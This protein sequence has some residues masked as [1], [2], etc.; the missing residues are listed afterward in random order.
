MLP[1]ALLRISSQWILRALDIGRNSSRSVLD[2]LRM[3]L[4][5]YLL[6]DSQAGIDASIQVTFR[7]TIGAVS[8]CAVWPKMPWSV[9][10]RVV[11][12]LNQFI[13]SNFTF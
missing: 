5:N 11:I 2:V 8:L 10:G 4:A 12:S 7:I 9:S 1:F 3:V 13:G 6:F